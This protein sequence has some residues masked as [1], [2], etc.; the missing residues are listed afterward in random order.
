MFELLLVA[1][2][3]GK[4]VIILESFQNGNFT[5]TE[6]INSL[7]S[8]YR[9]RFSENKNELCIIFRKIEIYPESNQTDGFMEE[10]IHQIDTTIFISPNPTS[11]TKTRYVKILNEVKYEIV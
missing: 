9:E 3:E 4:N 5:N 2:D 6:M 11:K 1:K 10:N 7:I 8:Q